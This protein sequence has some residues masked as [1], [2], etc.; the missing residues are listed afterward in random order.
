MNEDVYKMIALCFEA[1]KIMIQSKGDMCNRSRPGRAFKSG[2]DDLAKGKLCQVY[3]RII[4]DA[5]VVKN[6]R[7]VQVT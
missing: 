4:Q 1:V 3:G 6:E 5:G 7:P 2:L